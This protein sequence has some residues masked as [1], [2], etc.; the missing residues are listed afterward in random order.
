MLFDSVGAIS[1]TLV[2]PCAGVVIESKKGCSILHIKR[3]NNAPIPFSLPAVSRVCNNGS[4]THKILNEYLGINEEIS[5]C[6][7]GFLTKR[8]LLYINTGGR[9][10]IPKVPY[11]ST[12][13]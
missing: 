11:I 3:S 4:F 10:C 9:T 5:T 1:F 2:N 12:C 7:T 6:K 8:I 13:R